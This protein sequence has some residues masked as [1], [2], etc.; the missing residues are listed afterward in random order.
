[1]QRPVTYRG[2][3]PRGWASLQLRPPGPVQ[4]TAHETRLRVLRW[5]PCALL[6]L[7]LLWASPAGAIEL[8]D[9]LGHHMVLQR[10][11]PVPIWGR[12]AP[13]ET[14]AV[15]FAGQTK[16]TRADALGR[17]LVRLD[18]LPAE[19]R[20][21]ALVV[22]GK[23]GTLRLRDVLVGDVWIAGGQSNM[24]R[25][26]NSSWRPD[27]QKF[28][29]PQIRY[30][31]IENLGSKYPTEKMQCEWLV[32]NDQTTPECT[33]VGFF[34]AERVYQETNIP[35]GLLWNA[36]GGSTAREW[37][38]RFGWSLRPELEETARLVDS[39]YPS[40]PRGRQAFLDAVEQI[41]S[42]RSRAEE[43]V[44]QGHP[45][46]F[47][48]P[49]LPEPDD[50]GGRGRG[51][52][53]LYNGRVHPLVPY[54]IAGILWWQ[55]ES[56]YANQRYL[57]EIEAMVESWRRLF[58]APGEEPERLPFYFV[59]MQRSGTYMSPDVRDRQFQSYFTIPNAGMA[60]LIDIDVQL[61]PWNKYD[62][63]RRL[64]LWALAKR[65]GKDVVYSGPLYHDHRAEGD[66]IIVQFSHARGGLFIG[67]K[68]RLE[69]A[70]TLPDGRLTN[71]EITAD[72]RRWVPAE[73]RIEGER[74]IVWSARVERPLHVRYCWKSVADEPFLY[75]RAGLPAAQFNT[76]SDYQI[77]K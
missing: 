64:A 44:R 55:G 26:V 52:T 74:L 76:A 54:A 12:A 72:G 6:T 41:D 23:S 20:P 75:N 9:V 25:R 36:V 43:A 71:L 24:G 30:L 50:G 3:A 65:Y 28:D 77:P 7:A 8:A 56:D 51:T 61:H 11:K 38:P 59:Q 32:C 39:W 45:F 18:P 14:V 73:S 40:T 69:P 67:R 5:W 68:E 19:V 1:M 10:D 27:D 47:P 42:W 33:A 29:Y 37:I 2:I 57:R 66:R 49:M 16:T 35:Q 46:P 60:V 53:I 22:R 21:R 15:E 34:F 48:Q 17:W 63:G 62:A 31:R 70:K 4:P 13:G 58:A